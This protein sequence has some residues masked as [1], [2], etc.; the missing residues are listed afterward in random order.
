MYEMLPIANLNTADEVTLI[1]P[2][3]LFLLTLAWIG[4][5]ILRRE[6]ARSG[7]GQGRA[8]PVARER[9]R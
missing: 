5:Q 1:V 4:W 3:G 2:L 8:E 6:R 7:G 9:V